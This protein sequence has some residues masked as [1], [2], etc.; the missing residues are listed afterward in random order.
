MGDRLVLMLD[1]VAPRTVLRHPRDD[2]MTVESAATSIA[3]RLNNSPEQ[4]VG[5]HIMEQLPWFELVMQVLNSKWARNQSPAAIAS[6]SALVE[7][8]WWP[9]AR[10][11]MREVTL[12]GWMRT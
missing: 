11:R 3:K 6:A 2:F 12:S 5:G 1:E 8:G 7:G 10:R 9:Q 4:L